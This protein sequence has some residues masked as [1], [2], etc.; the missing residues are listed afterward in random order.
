MQKKILK[1]IIFSLLLLCANI[2]TN[3]VVAKNTGLAQ[4]PVRITGIVK[5]A[6]G[7]ALTG[8]SVRVK[9]TNTGTVTDVD[10]RYAVSVPGENAVLLFSFI[11]FTTYEIAAE[12]RRVIDVTLEEDM[13]LLDEVIVTGF[14]YLRKSEYDG[15]A[16]VIKTDNLTG[17]PNQT[18]SS[19]IQANAPG[20]SITNSSS[21]PGGVSDF[22]IRGFGSFS[23]SNA[24]LFVID[25]VPVMSGDVNQTGR[26]N[27]G[28]TDIMSTLNPNDISNITVIKDAAAASLWGSRAANGVLLITTKQGERNNMRVNFSSDFGVSDLAYKYRPTM[29]GEERKQFI[30]DA[31]V[32]RGMYVDGLS[33]SAAIAYADAMAE[34][35]AKRVIPY[36]SV[37]PWSGWTDWRAE[38]LRKGSHN[39]QELSVSGGSNRMT[40][41]SS[42]S[43][44]NSNGIQKNQELDRLTGRMNVTYNANNWLKLGGN[45]LFSDMTQSLGYDVDWYTSPMYASVIKNTPSDPVYKQ[46]GTYNTALIG[47]TSRNIVPFYEYNRNKQ[48]ITRTFN[49]VFLEVRP[50]QDITVKTT[51]SYDYSMVRGDVWDHPINADSPTLNGTSERSFTERRQLVWS[52][53]ANYVKSF[54][55]GHHVDALIAYEILDNYTNFLNGTATGFLNYNYTEISNGAV[56]T[57]VSGSYMQDRLVSYI[58]RVNYD[59]NYKYYLGGSIRRDG[60]SR[61]HADSRWGNLW[62]ASGGWRFTDEHFMDEIKRFITNGKLRV[63]YG[64]NGNRPTDYYSYLGLAS[65]SASYNGSTALRQS[66]IANNDLVW[67][68]NYTLNMGLDATIKNR[69]DLTFEFY[70]RITKDLFMSLP[71]SYTTG[72]SS[73]IT[74][75]GSLR[76]RGVELTIDSKNIQKRDLSWNT[77]FN[78]SYNKNEIIKLD[79][80]I[81]STEVSADNIAS[82]ATG[83]TPMIRR[84]GLPFYQYYLIE[85]SHVNPDNGRAMFF[86]NNKLPDGTLNRELTDNASLASRV[87]YKS[88]IPKTNIG[89]TNTIKWKIVDLSFTLSSTLGGYSYDRAANKTETSGASDA[90]INQ[91]HT[92][93]RDSWKKPGDN[94]KFEAW[95]PGTSS[96]YAMGPYHNTRRVHSTDHIRLKNINLGVSLPQNWTNALKINQVRVYFTGQNLWTL[97]AYDQYDPEV[98]VDGVMWYNTPPMK[99]YSFGINVNF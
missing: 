20:I 43:R 88:P 42:F 93:Y 92:F 33:E 32:R 26:S 81:I 49:T 57:S 63:S 53:N 91:L 27:S 65:I 41:Y 79:K 25:G 74:N 90:L 64:V 82:I 66:N 70:N 28:G 60:T 96:T 36:W 23:A 2:I 83:S 69:V 17:I 13:Q 3:D 59:W 84:E 21:Q 73:L 19:M 9:N 1:T 50:L 68:R 38:A 6:T 39:N 18:V 55:V 51:L 40:Y 35:D 76:N 58:S 72:F 47:G 62:S 48:R 5:D 86:M 78:I 80:E 85:Y 24:P 99:S 56:P 77:Q 75:I 94:A 31:Y 11:G 30:Y 61:L 67:E 34:T 97:A 52:S 15:S 8:V 54:G 89:L 29:S 98:P 7:E 14:G 12:N 46:D 44:S 95:I 71:I 45:L 16:S 87:P 10:G 37:E 4:Q 22:R